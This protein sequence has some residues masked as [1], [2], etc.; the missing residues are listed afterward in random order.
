MDGECVE[1][2]RDR[3]TDGG[4][5]SSGEDKRP[6][7]SDSAWALR[8]PTAR[9]VQRSWGGAG[10]AI[11]GHGAST[12][13]QLLGLLKP[14]APLGASSSRHGL[15]S[16]RLDV[17]RRVSRGCWEA[18]GEPTAASSSRGCISLCSSW[19]LLCP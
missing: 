5:R 17:S 15:S 10:L 2:E 13:Y 8:S 18:A 3:Q 4:V 19:G 12:M 7:D 16:L 1:C 6:W 9:H 11:G 14:R